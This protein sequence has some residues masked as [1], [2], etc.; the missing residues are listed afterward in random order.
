MIDS[1]NKKI[2]DLLDSTEPVLTSRESE[3]IRRG[4]WLKMRKH[5]TAVKL[6]AV[7]VPSALLILIAFAS[8]NPFGNGQIAES[9][10]FFFSDSDIWEE[11]GKMP[12]NELVNGML[13]TE[14]DSI[15]NMYLE[16]TE[17][18]DAISLLSE[19]EQEEFLIALAE[20]I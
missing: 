16:E 20:E 9:E 5:R 12:Q 10:L 2:K 19:D 18:E 7:L 15:A 1:Y 4:V 13:G 17:I 6:R 14:I 11:A 8:L 3:E